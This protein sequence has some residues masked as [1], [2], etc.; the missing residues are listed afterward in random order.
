MMQ[1]TGTE[2][3]T[4]NLAE[5]LTESG[6]ELIAS[7]DRFKAYCPF[8]KEDTPSF[9]IYPEQ[10]YYC[11]GCNVWGDAVKFLV[12]YK[13]MSTKEA[14]DYAGIENYIT[15]RADKA[16]VIKTRNTVQTWAFV[17]QVTDYYNEYL[18]RYPGPVNYLLGR[19]LTKETIDSYKL[20]YTDGK[21]LN[22]KFA[23]ERQLA[24]EIGIMNR[25]GYEMMSHRITIPNLVGPKEADFLMGRTV[26]N[27]NIKYLGA[28]MPKPLIGFHEVRKSP[29]IFMVEGQFDWLTLR[30]WG[31]PAICVSGNHLKPYIRLPLSGKTVVYIPDIEE[32][33]EG[34]K[35]GKAIVEK[36]GDSGILFDISVLRTGSDKLDVNSLAQRE[37][38]KRSFD[39]LVRSF[40]WNTH[41][42][43]V[44]LS[45]WLPNWSTPTYLAST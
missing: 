42:S 37:D 27:D 45:R 24:D 36:F 31:Y 41:L 23:W 44:Q 20:G 30:Q 3:H 9:T 10:N 21:V 13:G 16:K 14:M 28:R 6:I 29:I 12:D 17:W 33:G 35:A 2:R 19:G 15:N 5:I 34:M 25:D 7:G 32:S 39:E 4:K 11:F 26:T 40:N 18:N 43:N 38:G 22:L 1:L 8:H